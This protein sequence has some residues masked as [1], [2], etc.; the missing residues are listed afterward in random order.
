MTAT[1]VDMELSP[2]QAE[3]ADAALQVIAR[4]GLS[5]ASF[6]TV[7]AQA[8][9]S[10]GSLQKAFPS[11]ELLMTAAFARLREQ[12]APLPA[13]EPGRPT[14]K[15]W[16][17]ELL[18]GILP[19]DDARLAAQR[20]GDAF[21]QHALTDPAIGAAI[22]ESDDEVRGL[23]ASLVSRARAEG[24]IPATVD[25]A[26]TAWAVLALAQGLAAQLL[27]RPEPEAAV[28]DRL[29]QAVQALLR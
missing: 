28:R 22:A 6:R 15:G 25:P 8:G 4:D 20:Q 21:A 2:R 11:K 1:V 7:A 12:A 29:D 16:L 27:Y 9:R 3:F 13:G 24:E 5:G 14:L 18:I 26:A 17:V 19:L 10:L 23:L